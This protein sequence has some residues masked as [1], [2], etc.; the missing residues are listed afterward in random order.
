MLRSLVSI[1]VVLLLGSAAAGAYWQYVALPAQQKQQTPA[2]GRG[3][4]PVPVEAMPVKIAPAEISVEAVGSLLSNERVS[5]RPEV[6][7][8]IAAFHFEEG[9]KVTAGQLLVELDASVERATLAEARARLFLAQ[10]NLERAREL[11]RSNVGT[12]RALDEA[13]AAFRI[14]EAAVELAQAQLAKRQ[15]RAPFDARVG[16]RRAS[17]GEFVTAGTELTTLEQI[18]PIKVDFRV[19]E[20]FLP[21]VQVGNPIRITVDAFPDRSF[22][23]RVVAIDAALDERGRSLV[24]RAAIPNQD[25]LLRP[26]LFAR[27]QL[28]L[29]SKPEALWIA[30]EAL[31]PQGGA[32]FVFRLVDQGPGEPKRVERVPV[33]I[34]MRR[35]GEVEITEGLKPGD[36]V[37]TAGVMRVRDGGLALVRRPGEAPR[38]GGEGGVPTAGPAAAPS[39]RG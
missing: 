1:F 12:Q 9:G 5:V 8:R 38:R 7:G 6:S 10:T 26:G 30:E 39:G 3:N 16:L 18:D 32:Q 31:V 2:A 21:A 4:A 28:T 34:G 37:V 33:S 22:E 19:P 11:R 27:V 24:V 29:A 14:A 23:G 20:L 25:E 35:P 36:L 13:E 17:V 15:I